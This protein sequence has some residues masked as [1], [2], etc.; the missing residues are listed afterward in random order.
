MKLQ[1]TI[2]GLRVDIMCS[3]SSLVKSMEQRHPFYLCK[4]T[5]ISNN[6]W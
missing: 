4:L 1:S 5:N 3:P 6:L 2:T